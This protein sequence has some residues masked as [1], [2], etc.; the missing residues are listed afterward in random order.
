MDEIY[1]RRSYHDGFDGARKISDD[2]INAVLK[3]G[4]NAPSANNTQP[5]EFV[6]VDD[7]EKLTK[8]ANLK[9]SGGTRAA[10][11]ASHAIIICAKPDELQEMNVGI[12]LENIAL[13]AA[14]L[15]IGSLIMDIVTNIGTQKTVKELLDVPDG[16]T[17]YIM[18]AL[19]YP[20][21]TLPPNNRWLP[22]KIHTNK[23]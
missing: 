7:E 21:E 14:G 8:L 16:F 2:D 3:A 13:V 11:T 23:F 20:T 17:A 12:A 9:E 18:L 5:W 15:G 10:A 22:D 19:G 1:Q 4:M 6:V